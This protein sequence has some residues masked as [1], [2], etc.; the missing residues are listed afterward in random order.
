M[1]RAA[2]HNYAPG[3]VESHIALLTMAGWVTPPC[4]R[5]LEAEAAELVD[6]SERDTAARA[7]F[8]REVR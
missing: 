1:A 5:S 4:H 8:V 6:L 7:T 3:S 2:N